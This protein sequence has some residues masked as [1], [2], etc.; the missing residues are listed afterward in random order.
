M[1]CPI[2]P[3]RDISFLTFLIVVEMSCKCKVLN[4]IFLIETINFD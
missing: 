2:E 3:I 4:Y 1:P